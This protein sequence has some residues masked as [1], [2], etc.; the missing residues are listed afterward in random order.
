MPMPIS[1]KQFF[2]KLIERHPV[3]TLFAYSLLSE[4]LV[5]LFLFLAFLQTAEILLP[6]FIS[7]RLN[8]TW[9]LILVIAGTAI[10]L[11][12]GHRQNIRPLQTRRFEKPLLVLGELWACGVISFSLH[13]F[14]WWTIALIVVALLVISVW[15]WNFFFAENKG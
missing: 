2:L 13:H 12:I 6:G 11:L 15:A 10:I 4:L 9:Y 7:L 8:L 5:L 3:K 1:P 14:A